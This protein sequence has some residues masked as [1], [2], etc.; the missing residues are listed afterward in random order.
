MLELLKLLQL[1]V[2]NV[3][4]NK[5]R[6]ALTMGAIGFGVL[7]SLLLGSFIYGLGNV[8]IDDIVKGK[9]GALQVHRKGYDDVRENQPLDLDFA[10]H[11]GIVAQV[12]AVPGVTAIS[13]RIV[14]GG[15]LNNG[16]QS[17]NYVAIAFDPKLEYAA[18]PWATYGMTGKGVGEDPG[19][20]RGV[21][22]G[23]ELALAM[24]LTPG[25][26]AVLQAAAK[27]GQQ[28]AMDVDVIGSQ[29]NGNVFEAKRLITVPL[30]FAQELLGM[31]GR[32]TE[33][34]VAVQD[35]KKVEEV[36]AGIR[37]KLGAEWEV[38]TWPALR[39][40]VADVVRFQKVVLMSVALVFLVIAIIGVVNTMLMSV[41]ERTREIGTMLAVGMR[42]AKIT[43]LFLFEGVAL[44]AI[45]GTSGILLAFGIVQL[46][47]ARGGIPA[48][49]PGAT[50]DYVIFPDVA[51]EL[52]APVWIA[53]TLGTL[54]AA[55]W[56]AYKASRLRPVE[57]LR[58][59]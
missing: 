30:A 32:V 18:L 52:V 7:M 34:A 48:S 20:P 26:T 43:W 1:A 45:G 51:A 59:I 9:T 35:V 11:G 27:G 56:P 28:N 21:A 46:V 25:T 58:A 23:E 44:A 53:A 31:E 55:A 38:Q 47:V 8:M 16:T 40:N 24:Q 54:I 3:T 4:R 10:Q 14:F 17:T 15:I 13:P 39:P 12:A 22:L 5:S 37:A 49:A 6:S 2:R 50:A 42:R 57:A 36:A 41:L 29:N 19:K 33:L